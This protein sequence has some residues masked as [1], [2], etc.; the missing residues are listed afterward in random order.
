MKKLAIGTIIFMWL[1]RLVALAFVV[2]LVVGALVFASAP[3]PAPSIEKAPYGI[4]TYTNDV[5]SRAYY[6]QNIRL[7][8]NVPI[9]TGYWDFDG[10]D[11]KFHKGEKEFP[12]SKYSYVQIVDRRKR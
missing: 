12:P 8:G 7:E 1:S 5:P 6:A 2:L 4:Q 9:V 10:K 11:F 3:D